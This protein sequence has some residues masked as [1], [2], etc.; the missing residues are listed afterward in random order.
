MIWRNLKRRE[1]RDFGK[2]Y[3]LMIKDRKAVIFGV[4][5]YRLK[6]NEKIFLK[7][8]DLHSDASHKPVNA[9]SSVSLAKHLGY[10]KVIT[11]TGA[12]MNARA[13]AAAASKLGLEAEVHI[14]AVDAKKVS[15]NKDITEL[16]GANIIVVHDSTATLLPAM[17][18]ALRSWQSSPDAMYVVG[19]VAGPHPY[20]Q[21]VRTWASVI[22]RIAK[23]QFKQMEL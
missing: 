12:S 11:E 7:R 22:G 16:Y 17:A 13:V 14:G 20:P 23:K 10:K 4:S 8:T 2:I 5:S 15:L 3:Y 6:S 1:K 9:Y 18:S 19:S 21:M